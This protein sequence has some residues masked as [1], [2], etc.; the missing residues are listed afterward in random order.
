MSMRDRIISIIE[1]NN[2]GELNRE[3]VDMDAAAD[4]ILAALN[5]ELSAPN[6]QI[7][8]LCKQ[9]AKV[10]KERTDALARIEEL[11]TA[12]R[13]LQSSAQSKPHHAG[14]TPREY[15]MHAAI[16]EALKTLKE[17]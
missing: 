10:S 16:C 13:G 11:E 17:K 9:L 14:E 12:L 5:D 8:V 7:T 2:V 15:H 4:A 3:R 1:D 6:P